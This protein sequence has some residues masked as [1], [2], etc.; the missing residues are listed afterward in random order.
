[1][2]GTRMG[3]WLKLLDMK[4]GMEALTANHMVPISVMESSFVRELKNM[5]LF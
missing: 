4:F 3:W 1:M 5:G 2:A